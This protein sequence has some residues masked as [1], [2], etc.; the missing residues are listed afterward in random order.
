MKN[1]VLTAA[2]LWQPGH[3]D[4]WNAIAPYILGREQRGGVGPCRYHE[5]FMRGGRASGKS[6]TTSI[7]LVMT[8]TNDPE[9]NAVVIRKVGSSIRKSCFEQVKKALNRLGV[10]S[11]WNINQTNLTMTH[12]VTKQKIVFVG[13]DDE[14]KLRSITCEVGYFSFLWYEE[15]KQMDNYEEIQQARASILRGGSDDGGGNNA[16][17]ITFLTYNPPKSRLEWIN[18]EANKDV[19]G[20]IVH[21]STYLT[22]PPEWI[23]KAIIADAERLK[24]YDDRQYRYMY[25]G[26]PVGTTGTYFHN[27]HETEITDEMIQSF[28]YSDM[29]IDWGT[30]DPNV[31]GRMYLDED[32]R[33][34]WIFDEIYQRE[35][36]CNS[37]DTKIYEF[38]AAVKKRL[39]EIGLA[40]DPVWCDCQGKAEISIFRSSEYDIDAQPAPK[41]GDS[42]RTVGY[43]YLQKLKAI[44]IDPKRCPNILKDFLLFES[45]E[46]PN[47]KGWADKPGKKG[48]HGPDMVRYAIWQQ[49][50]ND[51]PED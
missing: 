22:M 10:L 23:G 34:L 46:L 50:L 15:A 13:A 43:G 26:E 47:K 11:Y 37:E 45:L 19:E 9:K 6:Y 24:K 51:C 40:D 35:E 3:N 41:Q 33:E 48:D 14:E 25:L 29:G 31:W 39:A 38:A 42:G 18:E 12:K 49:I 4:L 27:I 21:S 36:D 5:V 8:L 1:K 44:H 2:D 7:W 28:D 32:N 20:R 30:R 17:F 16:E